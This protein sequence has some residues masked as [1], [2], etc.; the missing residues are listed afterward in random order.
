MEI[1]AA[2]CMTAGWPCGLGG[3]LT[4]MTEGEQIPKLYLHPLHVSLQHGVQ[5][6]P[7]TAWPFHLQF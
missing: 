4:G 2:L 6:H 5:L 7:R 3:S 1:Y